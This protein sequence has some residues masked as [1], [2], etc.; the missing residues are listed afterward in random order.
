MCLGGRI[1]EKALLKKAAIQSV[2]L[3]LGVIMLSYAIKQYNNVAIYA[4]YNED[5][6]PTTQTKNKDIIQEVKHEDVDTEVVID[7][8]KEPQ[9]MFTGVKVGINNDILKQLGEKYLVIRKPLGEALQIQL[10]DLYIT[11]N[12]RLN[13]AGFMDEMLDINFIGRVNGEEI[14]IGDPTYLEN[15]TIE[16]GDDG[17]FSSTINRDYGNDP[18]NEILISNRT[19]DEEAIE[20]ELMLLLDHVYVYSLYEDEYYYY[21]DMRSPRELYDKILVIDA[22][23]G[24][25]NPGAVSKDELTYEKN[26]NLVILLELKEL[27]DKENI[28]VYYT[29]IMDD[30]L[31]LTPRVELAN[32]VDCDFFISIHNN[33]NGR[34]TKVN[35]TEILYY[36]HEHKGIAAKKMAKIFSEEI[37][38]AT[39]LKNN[40][41]VQLKNDDVL[42]LN[43]AKVPAIMVEAG[44]M[45]NISDLE[46]IKSTA[47]QEAI[48]KGIYRG[49]LRLYEEFMP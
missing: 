45:S 31:L 1:L 15:E 25:K 36:D 3:M 14:F 28:K 42:I 43:H 5:I 49:I 22:G 11:K 13:I 12:L 6:T 30:K 32:D 39:S 33:S 17:S 23:H 44:Y 7:A 29:R 37:F 21:I 19:S 9:I 26:I 48:A 2:A 8:S 24:G 10:E 34:S 20:I 41:L 38:K 16:Q 46:Y 4:S 27:L 47:G 35:G 18:V 40:G